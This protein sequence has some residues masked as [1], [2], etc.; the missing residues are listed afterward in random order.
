V[1]F[2][3]ALCHP[4]NSRAHRDEECESEKMALVEMPQNDVQTIAKSSNQA[5][6]RVAIITIEP[7]WP[8]KATRR[9]CFL[10]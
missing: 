7:Q 10:H 1:A 8:K 6:Y 9:I 2:F 4:K 3:Y 5:D